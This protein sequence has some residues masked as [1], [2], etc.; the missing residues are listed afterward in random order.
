MNK[1]NGCFNANKLIHETMLSLNE[2]LL[3]VHIASHLLQ[4]TTFQLLK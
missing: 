4:L 2:I 3:A 1:S